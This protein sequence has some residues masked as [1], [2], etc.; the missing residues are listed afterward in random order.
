MKSHMKPRLL[1]LALVPLALSLSA[2][3]FRGRTVAPAASPTPT[4]DPL[5]EPPIPPNPTELDLGHNR[6]WH[7]CM[8]CHGDRGQG[9]TDEFRR[10][11]EPDH[12]NCWGRGCHGGRPQDE[13]FPIPTVVPALRAADRLA[14][15]ASLQDLDA[16]LTSTHPPQRPGSLKPEEYRAIAL[17]VFTL[18]DHSPVSASPTPTSTPAAVPHSSASSLPASTLLLAALVPLSALA[19]F[20]FFRALRSR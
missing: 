15:F 4:Y 16:Y 11:W 10:I 8:P 19:A 5:V 13:G 6:Y 14:R 17:Y 20:F 3:H 1:I 7:W 18:N 12:Q 2:F 9:L